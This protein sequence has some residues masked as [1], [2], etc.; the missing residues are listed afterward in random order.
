[1]KIKKKINISS[2]N[3]I[4]IPKKIVEELG[5]RKRLEIEVIDKKIIITPLYEE[6]PEEILKRLLR[7]GLKD[8][9][10]FSEFKKELKKE[11]INKKNE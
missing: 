9:V 7:K 10:L 3:Q 4:T 2:Q 1:M 6:T 11:E 5:I 8:K